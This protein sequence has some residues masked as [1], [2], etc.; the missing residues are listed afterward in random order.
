MVKTLDEW[1]TAYIALGS[2]LF[3]KN[4]N[5]SKAIDQL[6]A[7]NGLKVV[8]CS[9][10]VATK[11]EGFETEHDFLNAVVQVESNISPEYLLNELLSIERDMGRVRSEKGYSDRPI[12][13]DIIAFG[14]IIYKS[15]KLAIPHPEM[16]KRS[17]VLAPLVE[18]NKDWLHPRL[19][20]TAEKLLMEL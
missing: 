12:D 1:T 13:L 14:E 6:D 20:I 5:L 7:I 11:A 15:E 17:F 16:H 19:N 4:E 3:N 10:F 8:M 18:I 9:K 2:N